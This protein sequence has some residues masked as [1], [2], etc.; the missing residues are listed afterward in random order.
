MVTVQIKCRYRM[1]LTF[2][3]NVTIRVLQS[4]FLPILSFL[5][6][7]Y[8]FNNTCYILESW[9][10]LFCNEFFVT[11]SK[12]QPIRF[13]QE[14]KLLPAT[15]SVIDTEVRH[16]NLC[17]IFIINSDLIDYI[18]YGNN[19]IIYTLLCISWPRNTVFR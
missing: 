11:F 16:Y 10:H 1:G 8:S 17:L 2:P 18:M 19:A 15:F 12:L 5:N 14:S 9:I 4:K 3:Q 13:R 7:L 6:T